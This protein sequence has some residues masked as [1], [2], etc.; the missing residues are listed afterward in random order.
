MA[1]LP[2]S[3]AARAS[4]SAL[5]AAYD[6]RRGRDGWPP[7][8]PNVFGALLKPAVAAAGGRKILR[9]IAKSISAS[10]S[11]PSSQGR[12]EG[13]PTGRSSHL[14]VPAHDLPDWE[15]ELLRCT[16]PLQRLV[17]KKKA[18]IRFSILMLWKCKKKSFC[19]RHRSGAGGS[20]WVATGGCHP[21]IASKAS[22]R[23]SRAARFS[24]S[25][26]SP[27][28]AIRSAG[29][30]REC[31]PFGGGSQLHRRTERN[32]SL[33]PYRCPRRPLSRSTSQHRSPQLT[34]V[35]LA[36]H[37]HWANLVRVSERV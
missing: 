19:V 4:G 31:S 30:L 1:L 18:K 21:R 23:S 24:T 36:L 16:L 20:V 22:T 13:G 12:W 9:A 11:R 15:D 29:R 26:I 35:E 37:W 33:R 7:I 5:F 25:F 2:R 6:D 32:Y 8:Q 3:P 28:E 10:A 17:W 27:P 34:D 14:I